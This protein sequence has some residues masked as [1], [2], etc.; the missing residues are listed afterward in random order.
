ME[1][2]LWEVRVWLFFCDYLWLFCDFKRR[3]MEMRRR[4]VY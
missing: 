1:E 2:E 4:L 3:E